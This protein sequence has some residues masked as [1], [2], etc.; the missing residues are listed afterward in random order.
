M[1]RVIDRPARTGAEPSLTE[2]R[3]FN[4]TFK[5]DAQVA[6]KAAQYMIAMIVG[7]VLLIITPTSTGA[8]WAGTPASTPIV[9]VPGTGSAG[10]GDDGP[11]PCGPSRDGQL[12]RDPWNGSVWQCRFTG[13]YW[14]WFM[15]I[16]SLTNDSLEFNHNRET[17]LQLSAC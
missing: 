5:P 15:V 4:M 12:W 16:P 3:E 8:A 6:A 2:V 9:T 17:T 13:C 1:K 10:A 14:G 11:P 7:A